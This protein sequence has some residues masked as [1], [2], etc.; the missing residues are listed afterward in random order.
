MAGGQMTRA[1]I[2]RRIAGAAAWIVVPGMTLA[3]QSSGAAGPWTVAIRP[4][5][6]PLM[7]GQ[8]TG[9]AIDR[10]D[11]SGRDAPKTPAGVLVSIAD[12]DMNV[13]AVPEAAVIGRYN[14]S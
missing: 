14:R 3:A 11:R 10:G 7:I 9:V 2:V 13:A 12:F 4:N 6:S 5:D 1:M 8:C